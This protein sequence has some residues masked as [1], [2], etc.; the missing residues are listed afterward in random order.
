MIKQLKRRIS[1]KKQQLRDWLELDTE[2]ESDVDVK[3][4]LEKINDPR[5]LQKTSRT[6]WRL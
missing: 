5:N 2:I 4:A 3:A 6:K 1:E